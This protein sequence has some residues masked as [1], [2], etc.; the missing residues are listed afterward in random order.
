MDNKERLKQARNILLSH[1][2]TLVDFERENYQMLNGPVNSGQFLNL[3]LEDPDFEWLREFSTLIVGID[4]MFELK[5]GISSEMVDNYLA[6]MKELI[7]LKN[8]SEA[9]KTKYQYALQE[10]T[11]AA[12]GHA[13]LKRLL[14][15]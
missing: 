13:E 12:G 6:K 5:D 9:F 4:E 2:K 10:S 3:L 14:A 11:E 15:E 7:D 1:H 8:V